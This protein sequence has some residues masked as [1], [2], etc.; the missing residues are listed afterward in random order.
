MPFDDIGEIHECFNC[1]GCICEEH[2]KK[3]EEK[4]FNKKPRKK[5]GE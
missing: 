4:N 2:C 3:E 1:K 5:E